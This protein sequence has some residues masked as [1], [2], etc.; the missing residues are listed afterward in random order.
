[1]D[2]LILAGGLGTRLRPAVAD[3]AK[4]VAPVAGRPFLSYVMDHL[5]KS[6]MVS[7]FI[8][9]VGHHADSVCEAFGSLSSDI[10][11]LY[12]RESHPLG[13]GGALRQAAAELA[14]APPFLALNGDTIIRLRIE[15]FV[16]FHRAHKA[17]LTLALSHAKNAERFGTVAL[18]GARITSFAA[19]GNAVRGWINGGMYL[20][21][22]RATRALLAM[23][24]NFSLENDFFPSQISTLHCAG[25]RTRASFLDIGTP[26]DYD[27]AALILRG[28]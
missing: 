25:Y 14:P 7:R 16:A 27:R 1:M 2:A 12:S 23:P 22:P 10:P 6:G 19:R 8:L 17:D 11:I 21:S 4:S 24:E 15:N 20:F 26:D 9:C 3:R 13:T 28:H 5:A 18:E